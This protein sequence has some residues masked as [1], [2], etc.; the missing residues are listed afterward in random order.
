MGPVLR[1]LAG[2]SVLILAASNALGQPPTEM[3]WCGYGCGPIP[4]H[5]LFIDCPGYPLTIAYGTSAQH[6]YGPL[7]CVGPIEVSLLISQ[8]GDD[9][10]TLPLFVQIVEHE[11]P[12]CPPQTAGSLLWQ[13]YGGISCDPDSLW[14]TSPPLDVPWVVGLGSTYWILL[15]GFARFDQLGRSTAES[16]YL[17]CGRVRVATSITATNW[18]SI[19]VLYR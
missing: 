5:V 15:E 4:A 13:T 16:P 6:W 7:R 2:V 14:F 11:A 10:E 17:A 3:D 8:I 18:S 12:T 19:K 1:W 9:V